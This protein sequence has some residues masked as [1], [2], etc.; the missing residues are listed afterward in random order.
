MLTKEIGYDPGFL[1]FLKG[2]FQE[3]MPKDSSQISQIAILRLDGDWYDST[4]VCLEFLYDKVVPGGFVII[5][6]YGA[7]EGCRKAVA[8]FRQK[9]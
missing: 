2:W 3:T 4:R 8:E 1:H 6:N 5:D 7:Y 9:T